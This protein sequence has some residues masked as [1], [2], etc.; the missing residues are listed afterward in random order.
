MFSTFQARSYSLFFTIS[1]V[2][3]IINGCSNDTNS[4]P[5]LLSPP[6]DAQIS[7]IN[8]TT[9]L[10]NGMDTPFTQSLEF[11]FETGEIPTSYSFFNGSNER[12]FLVEYEY[13]DNLLV[14]SNRLIEDPPGSNNL[15]FTDSV[16]HEYNNN[17]RS[18]AVEAFRR[19]DD[20]EL[21]SSRLEAIRDMNGRIVSQTQFAIFSGNKIANRKVEFEYNRDGNVEKR[22]NFVLNSNTNELEPAFFREYRYEDV[23]N[24]FF[25]KETTG[26]ILRVVGLD[27]LLSPNLP[28]SYQNFNFESDDA[29][30][31]GTIEYVTNEN[32]FPLSSRLIFIVNAE[33]NDEGT[34]VDSEYE[35]HNP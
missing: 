12:T 27:E 19:N 18:I 4:D 9:S 3:L 10:V 16:L 24:P 2:L 15:V 33:P 28:I 23:K 25:N 29:V 30:T 11:N 8:E 14:S 6:F 1:V 35:Y 34:I 7:S 5:G 21:I 32:G 26:S 13:E 17:G 31:S 22:T 20:G